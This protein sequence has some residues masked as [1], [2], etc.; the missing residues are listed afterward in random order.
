[1]KSLFI[2]KSGAA[3]AMK[4]SMNDTTGRHNDGTVQQYGIGTCRLVRSVM[5]FNLADDQDGTGPL[6]EKIRL[7]GT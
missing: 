5:A 4:R 2:Q 1:M 3:E 6:L 7:S